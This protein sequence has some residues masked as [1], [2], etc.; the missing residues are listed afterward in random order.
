MRKI[1]FVMKIL[2]LNR[3]INIHSNDHSSCKIV[4]SG[5][6]SPKM[7][8]AIITPFLTTSWKVAT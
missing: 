5:T 1:L 6:L 2:I 3:I 8:E 4:I 7:I